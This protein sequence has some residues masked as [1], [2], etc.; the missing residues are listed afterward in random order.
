MTGEFDGGVDEGNDI[1]TGL[2]VSRYDEKLLPVP[3]RVEDPDGHRLLVFELLVEVVDSGLHPSF[4]GDI[5]L[6]WGGRG[7]YSKHFVK[8]WI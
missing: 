6:I 8:F 5:L 3:I 7:W 2:S 1:V 4:E